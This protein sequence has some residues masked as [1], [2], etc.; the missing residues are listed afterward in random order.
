MTKIYLIRHTQSTGNVEKRLTGRVDYEVTED[1]KRQ[2]DKLTSYL[3]DIKFDVAYASTSKRA[4]KT[5]EPLCIK[6]GIK[7]ILDENLCEMYFGV[8]DGLTWDEVNQLDIFVHQRH[9]QTNEI[10]GIPEQETTQQV[11][12]RMYKTILDIS[13]QN[14]GKNILI[15]SHGVA[16]E[17][18]LRKITGVPF[19]EEREAYSQKNTAINQILFNEEKETFKVI[20]LNK[21]QHLREIDERKR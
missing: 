20:E 13:N 3:K 14:I 1:G 9:M 5:I 2:I 19:I 16:I 12:N 17:A 8:Y 6:N 7:I 21:I 15:A 18:F 4:I 10:M 11:A